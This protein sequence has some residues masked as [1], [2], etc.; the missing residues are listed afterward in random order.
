M[1]ASGHPTPSPPA[2]PTRQRLAVQEA[3]RARIA[4]D[5]HDELG[6]LL[7]ALRLS[8]SALAQT[9]QDPAQQDLACDVLA[10][11]QDALERIRRLARGLHPPQLDS[12]GLVAALQAL[13][14]DLSRR[15][16]ARL[17]LTL[18]TP[19]PRA[20]AEVELAAYRIAQEAISN[21][22][23]HGQATHVRLHLSVEA[24]LLQLQIDDDGRG[25][26]I[27]AA[28]GFGRL[29]MRERATALG[30]TLQETAAATGTCLIARLPLH[31]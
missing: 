17:Q 23:R 20:A 2:L 7:T 16:P 4:R 8:A 10:L 28:P 6:Q 15:G 1:S 14:E 3:E 24:S 27:D 22:L 19:V 30:G 29:A 12:F 21:A 31:A 18:A 11:A 5:L 13:C 9:L 26:D 25:H